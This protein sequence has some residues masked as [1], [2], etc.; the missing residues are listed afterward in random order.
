MH[1]SEK[2]ALTATL[3]QTQALGPHK[4][5]T[6][7]VREVQEVI[8]YSSVVRSDATYPSCFVAPSGLLKHITGSS[9]M[10]HSYMDKVTS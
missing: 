8:L 3:Y 7:N 10:E 1:L 5:G 9:R 4:I 6:G 2:H